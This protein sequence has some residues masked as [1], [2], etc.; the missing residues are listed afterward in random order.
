M[1]QAKKLRKQLSKLYH[2]D[3]SPVSRIVLTQHGVLDKN[4]RQGKNFKKMIVE[5][6]DSKK[7]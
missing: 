1:G 6:K 7:K 3:P 2:G 4:G 5:P